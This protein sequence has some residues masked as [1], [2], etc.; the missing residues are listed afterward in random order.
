MSRASAPAAPAR[1][2]SAPARA[3]SAAPAPAC[4][5]SAAS[6][7]A[8]AGSAASAPACAGRA[9]ARA[10]P[11]RAVLA[12][13]AAV[14]SLALLVSCAGT[15]DEPAAATPLPPLARLSL[16][17]FSAPAAVT[18]FDAARSQS[19]GGVLTH[20]RF[21]YGD[22]SALDD[23]GAPS[24]THT[25]AQEGVFAVALEVQDAQ[26]RTARAQ[27]QIT[28]RQNPPACTSASDCQ[29][30][31]ACVSSRCTATVGSPP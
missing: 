11:A 24:A 4:A 1:A 3:G 17:R 19:P 8:C 25:F 14:A 22:G 13:A 9:L 30:P 5:G 15:A 18:P 2:A 26:G 23:R 16:P 10:A 6:A 28:I 21:S 12:R 31:D 29:P 27:G 7:P 20:Y